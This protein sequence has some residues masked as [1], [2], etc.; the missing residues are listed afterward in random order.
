MEKGEKESNFHQQNQAQASAPSKM[1]LSAGCNRDLVVV[2]N[3]LWGHAVRD[4]EASYYTV[5]QE[6]YLEGVYGAVFI[7]SGAFELPGDYSW[8]YTD[9][10]PMTAGR[11]H[12]VRSAGPFGCSLIVLQRTIQGACR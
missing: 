1:P 6:A 10:V 7:I 2:G 11:N 4:Y 8:E 3:I 12:G 5:R 9:L